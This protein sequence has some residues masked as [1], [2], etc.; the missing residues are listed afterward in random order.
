MSSQVCFRRAALLAALIVVIGF[1]LP[2]LGADA[3]PEAK[4]AK[5]K[6]EV[7]FCLDTTGSMSGLIQGA[8]DK[9]WAISNQ[10]AGGKPTPDLKIG[11]VA[12]RDRGREEYVTKI[13]ELTD[14]L[15]A[16][17]GKLREFKADGGGDAPE[18]VNQALDDAVNKIKWSTDKKT[19][20]IIFLVGDAP[21]HVDYADDVKYPVTC[22][23]ACEKGIIINTIQ[24]GGDGECQKHW[25]E[26]CKLAE[27]S[28]AQ[29]AQSGGVVAVATPYD[30][31]LAEI[32]AK[33][34]RTTLVYG[35]REAKKAANEKLDGAR[36][37]P[38][39]AAAD[40]AAFAARTHRVAAFDLLDDVKSGKVKLE[41][42]KKEEL[43]AEMRKMDLK[44]QKEY[45]DKLDKER[46]ELRKKALELDKKR[47]E[48][49]K[50]E[51]E[52]RAKKDGKDAKDS[53]DN[54]VLETLRTQAK[55]Y[56]ID[57]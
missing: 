27:G 44:Q 36:A 41:N 35:R 46:A 9:I 19:L 6:I 42:I 25:K 24:C 39:P 20:R 29:I 12:Y 16:I 23:K 2:A 43:P 56:N 14:D 3:K 48:H 45:L 30:K 40:R 31:E 11:L 17:H 47:A 4:K 8:K 49:I 57:Y 10:I 13:V 51:L 37:L 5:P 15:D 50:K 18:S 33:L 26:I 34:T 52:K 22:K 1:A 32:N 21:P 28:Y 54:Q 53:F 7:V 38:A 55:K